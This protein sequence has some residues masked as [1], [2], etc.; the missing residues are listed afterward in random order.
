[1]RHISEIIIH[2][3]ATP[4]GRDYTLEQIRGWHL[5]RGFADVAYHFIIHLDGS[6]D[7]GR[8][9][10]QPGAHCQGHNHNSVGVVYVGGLAA[11]GRTPKDTRTDRQKAALRNLVRDLRTRFPGAS[12]HGHREFANKDCP[13]F[14][15]QKDL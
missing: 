12:L 1:M 3:T 14:N 9:L 15:V 13:C 6:V 2:C 4:E 11:D 7:Q 10:T 5:A 8:P